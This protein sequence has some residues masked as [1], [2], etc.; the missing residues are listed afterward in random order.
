MPSTSSNSVWCSNR[1]F[2]EQHTLRDRAAD[3]LA[4]LFT[5]RLYVTEKYGARWIREEAFDATVTLFFEV[6]SCTCKSA[7]SASRA[8]KA[9]DISPVICLT[10]DLWSCCIN[11]RLSVR[12]IIE[13]IC[14]VCIL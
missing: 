6:P 7:T 4:Q 1:N 12:G 13:L 9:I 8:R 5:T 14:P 10:P 2:V 3:T 11:V